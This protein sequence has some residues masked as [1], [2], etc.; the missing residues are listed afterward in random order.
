VCML[1]FNAGRCACFNIHWGSVHVLTVTGAGVHVL[2]VT[3]GRCACVNR[4]CEPVCML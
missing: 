2:T 3:E 1:T 4:L